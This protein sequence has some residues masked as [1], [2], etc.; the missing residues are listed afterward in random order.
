MSVKGAREREEKKRRRRVRRWRGDKE[1][2]SDFSVFQ[3][4]E[5]EGLKRAHKRAH[6][7]T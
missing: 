4:K 6:G 3:A 1:D 5:N 7:G 2:P